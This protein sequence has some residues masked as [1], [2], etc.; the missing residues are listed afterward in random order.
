MSACTTL[1]VVA[2]KTCTSR[3][4]CI[5]EIFCFLTMGSSM[6]DIIVLDAGHFATDAETG[7]AL[8]VPASPAVLSHRGRISVRSLWK[9][10]GREQAGAGNRKGR[11]SFR[12]E[13]AGC[14]VQGERDR[15]LAAIEATY[16]DTSVFDYEMEKLFSEAHGKR[17]WSQE[18]VLR[19]GET[20]ELYYD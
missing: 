13:E 17:R 14:E 12:L 16:G 10:A 9:S 6:S 19:R 2:G 1:I 7:S 18:P 20:R 15:I 5:V 4:W 8:K 3:L 11:M